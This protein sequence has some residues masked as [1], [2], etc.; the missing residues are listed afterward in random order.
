VAGGGSRGASGGSA[1]GGGS[2]ADEQRRRQ[3]DQDR[4]NRARAD[5]DRERERR[6]GVCDAWRRE[7]ASAAESAQ[8]ANQACKQRCGDDYNRKLK[9][10]TTDAKCG[11]AQTKQMNDER[12]ACRKACPSESP[13]TRPQPAECGGPGTGAAN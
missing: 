8:R 7:R 12:D 4:A 9:A 10:C 11:L 5:A 3:A 2:A 13:S 1:G 6:R